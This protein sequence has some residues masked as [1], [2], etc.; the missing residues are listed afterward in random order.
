[1]KTSTGAPYLSVVFS[2][3]NEECV[4]PELIRRVRAA[5]AG[6]R[7]EGLVGRHEII[8]VNDASND[9][10]LALLKEQAQGHDDIRII[11]MSRTF[12]VAPCVLA[13]FAYAQGDAVVY[14]DADLQD[15]PEIIPD[16]LRAWQSDEGVEVVHTQRRLRQG[17]PWFKILITNIG[18]TIL[19]RC[20]TVVI[21][22]E[23]GDFKLLSRRVVTHLLQFHEQNPFMRGLVAWVGFKQVFVQYDRQ[24]RFAG[25]SKFFVL[26]RKVISNFFNSAIV[27]YSV[28]PL[29]VA[30]YLGFGVIL[31]DLLLLARVFFTK[32]QLAD[33]PGGMIILMAVL[34]MGGVQLLCLGVIGL[35]LNAVHEQG[36]KRP[37]YIVESTFGFSTEPSDHAAP[38]RA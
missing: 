12:G 9:R 11:N 34:F 10:S 3:R 4:L 36:K 27:N 16:M 25:D 18:Y 5:V 6:A 29:H 20:C 31:L 22:R 30:T 24:A 32:A 37:A 8:F 1:M 21:P 7:A 19:N 2:F 26:G 23:A 13:G 33:V 17:E 35:Y 28:L 14:M 38:K 15:P